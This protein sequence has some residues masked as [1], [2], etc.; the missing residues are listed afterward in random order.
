MVWRPTLI[1]TAVACLSPVTKEQPNS[2]RDLLREVQGKDRLKQRGV[3]DDEEWPAGDQGR[4]RRRQVPY[5]CDT[6][7]DEL[8]QAHCLNKAGFPRYGFA[9]TE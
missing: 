8:S 6:S 1:Y 2:H 7:G 9:S 3:G 4:V 5:R